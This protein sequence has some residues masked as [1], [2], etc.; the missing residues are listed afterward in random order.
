MK[1][2]DCK[3]NK[4]NPNLV[5]RPGITNNEP[6]VTPLAK[7]KRP[8]DETENAIYIDPKVV[9]RV[10]SNR[11]SHAILGNANK[12][13][14]ITS[15][16][17]VMVVNKSQ[18]STSTTLTAS[19][20]DDDVVFCGTEIASKMNAVKD[21]K[22][23]LDAARGRTD[24]YMFMAENRVSSPKNLDRRMTIGGPVVSI[25]NNQSNAQTKQRNALNSS[26][27]SKP[28]ASE[29]ARNVQKEMVS[30]RRKTTIDRESTKINIPLHLAKVS[31]PLS[32]RDSQKQMNMT[33]PTLSTNSQI[34]TRSRGI[35]PSYA[36][37]HC[38]YTTG[39]RTNLIRH[40]LTHTGEKPFTCKFCEKGFT[41]KVN[42]LSHMRSNHHEMHGDPTYW[43]L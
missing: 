26:N 21:R 22:K 24:F 35:A 8:D 36:C 19:K 13:D 20:L 6:N 43:E 41:Q 25:P 15:V 1:S 18:V 5:T 23:N 27:Q 14:S 9:Q 17:K 33:L 42:L 16:K 37:D 29:N 34:V 40:N 12:N 10:H 38:R 7:R 30:A 32:V 11:T 31:K 2:N 3:I 39:V 4:P 28:T